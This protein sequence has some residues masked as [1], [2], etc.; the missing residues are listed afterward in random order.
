MSDE[1][2][3]RKLNPKLLALLGAVLL[4][5]LLFVFVGRPLLFGDDGDEAVVVPLPAAPAEPDEGAD[6]DATDQADGEAPE[7]VEDTLEVF[8]ARDPF[9]QLVTAEGQAAPQT[10]EVPADPADATPAG[11]SSVRLDG[12]SADAGGTVRARLVVDGS[13]HEPAVGEAFAG[14]FQLLGVQDQCA[15]LASGEQRYALCAGD[16]IRA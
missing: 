15:T 2:A 11:D 3:D 16:E 6:G 12:V 8:R 10:V 13:P 5:A 1:N 14:R 4:A 7:A 9:Q